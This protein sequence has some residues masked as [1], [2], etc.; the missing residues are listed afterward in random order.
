M[1]LTH[2]GDYRAW[3]DTLAHP[4]AFV[5]EFTDDIASEVVDSCPGRCGGGF[6][7]IALGLAKRKHGPD[8]SSVISPG[9][10][11]KDDREIFYCGPQ[12]PCTH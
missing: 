10:V 1:P 3:H 4:L 6:I 2:L 11:R 5:Q 9:D 12:P 7:S 8:S